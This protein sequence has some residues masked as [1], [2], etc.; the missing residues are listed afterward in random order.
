LPCFKVRDCLQK[1]G[2]RNA[3]NITEHLFRKE[4]PTLASISADDGAAAK[5][6]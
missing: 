1:T 4:S 6:N 5:A 3:I 2:A